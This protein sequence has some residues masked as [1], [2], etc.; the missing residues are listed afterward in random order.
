MYV[1][2]SRLCLMK[3]FCTCSC[4]AYL[5]KPSFEPSHHTSSLAHHGESVGFISLIDINSIDRLSRFRNPVPAKST[6][7]EHEQSSNT[8][9]AADISSQATTHHWDSTWASDDDSYNISTVTDTFMVCVYRR[10]QNFAKP[11]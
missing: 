9:E 11:C 2:R 7:Y 5:K 6:Y 3:H 4:C 8:I 10:F 1:G